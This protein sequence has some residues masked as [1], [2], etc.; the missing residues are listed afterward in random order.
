MELLTHLPKKLPS[1][2]SFRK[3]SPIAR[4]EYRNGLLFLLPWFVGFLGFTLLPML[5]TLFFTFLDMKILTGVLSAPKFVGLANYVTLFR[6]NQI[7]KTQQLSGGFVGHVPF[8]YHR[9]TGWDFPPYGDRT[10]DEQ[11]VVEGQQFLP[12]D[13]LHALYHSFRSQHLPVG[14]PAQPCQR[15]DQ[16]RLV[17]H[18]SALRFPARLGK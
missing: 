18:G 9:P 15:L 5:A 8:W 17:S 14:W 16:Q 1:F 2:A 4:R 10:P 13:V 6:D 12:L 3:M 11:Q 7:W